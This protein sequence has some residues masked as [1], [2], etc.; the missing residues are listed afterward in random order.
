M[1]KAALISCLFLFQYL[2][3]NHFI[4]SPHLGFLPVIKIPTLYIFPEMGKMIISVAI[5]TITEINNCHKGTSIRLILAGIII[6]EAKGNIEPALA[7][8][9]SGFPCIP[10]AIKKGIIII[11]IRGHIPDWASWSLSNMAPTDAN[12]PINVTRAIKKLNRK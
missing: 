10:I 2:Y 3:F 11:I 9:L 4:T 1:K 5:L 6:N 7:N 12:I 8:V